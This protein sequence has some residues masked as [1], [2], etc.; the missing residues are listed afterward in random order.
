VVKAAQHCRALEK[1]N[2]NDE[3]NCCRVLEAAIDEGGEG[4]PVLRSRR[5]ADGNHEP[6]EVTHLK[7][8]AND[9]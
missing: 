2:L 7:E 9:G 3:G 4:L 5:A 8:N 6:D 1:E